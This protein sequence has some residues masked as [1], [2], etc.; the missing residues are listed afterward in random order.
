MAKLGVKK[1]YR[2]IQFETAALG[3]RF[4]VVSMSEDL[5]I[6]QTSVAMSEGEWH[7]VDTSSDFRIQLINA[8]TGF[9]IRYVSVAPDASR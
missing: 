6:Q 7:I 4:Q 5:R 1:I 2:P 3:Y 8:V 9:P